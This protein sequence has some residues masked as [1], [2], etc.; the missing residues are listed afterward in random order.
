M[1][2]FQCVSDMEGSWKYIMKD[3]FSKSYFNCIGSYLQAEINICPSSSLIFNA[4]MNTPFDEV[5]VVII[6]QDPYHGLNQ[7]MGLSFSVQD[8]IRIPPS[9][10]NIYRE[11]HADV[12]GNIPCTGNLTFWAKQ[13]VLLLNSILTVR[14]HEPNSHAHIGWEIFTDKVIQALSDKKKG[15][16]FLLW[17][18]FAQKKIVYIDTHKHFI[19]TAAHPSPYSAYKGFFGSKQFSKTNAFLTQQYKAPIQWTL[20]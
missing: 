17:G 11:I 19:L 20:L 12:G 3:E 5:K 14:M 6:G 13:G 1:D 4:F 16:V 9:L 7:A 18:A 15:I 8:Y 2:L 10:Q